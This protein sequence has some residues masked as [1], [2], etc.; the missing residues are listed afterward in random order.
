MELT[1]ALEETTG[2]ALSFPLYGLL[3]VSVPPHAL[4]KKAHARRRLKVF[5]NLPILFNNL[6]GSI[7]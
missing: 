5:M 2:D 7:C 1:E 4:K 6:L 3:E